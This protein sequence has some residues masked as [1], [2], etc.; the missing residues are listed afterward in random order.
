MKTLT[1]LRVTILYIE[2]PK[3][4]AENYESEIVISKFQDINS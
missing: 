3:D 1:V 4:S 2:N